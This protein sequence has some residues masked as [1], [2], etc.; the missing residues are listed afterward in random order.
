[1]K[2]LYA[3]LFLLIFFVLSV[4]A[5]QRL[6][7][8]H[9]QLTTKLFKVKSK[10]KY[11]LDTTQ[12]STIQNSSSAPTIIGSTIYDYQSNASMPR[13]IH[14]YANGRVTCI[15]NGS[16]QDQFYNDRG[17][18]INT[19]N[20]TSWSTSPLKR[21]ENKITGWCA[22]AVSTN[23]EH[24]IAEPNIISSNTGFGTAFDTGKTFTHLTQLRGP[25]A[26]ASG[27]YIHIVMAGTE[28]D[29]STGFVAPIYYTRSTNAGQSFEPMTA[30]FAAMAGYDTS[31]HAGNVGPNAYSIDAQGNTVAILVLGV[32]EDVVLLKSI[33]NGTTWT[34]TIIREFP[35]KKYTGGLTDKN[36]DGLMDT[37]LGVTGDGSIVIDNDGVVHVVFSDLELFSAD[38]GEI[39]IFPIN[40]SDYMNYWNDADKEIIEVPV[41]MDN[42]GNGIFDAGSNFTGNGN[43]R[44][45]NSGY[46]LNPQLSVGKSQTA[47]ED[48]IFL[49]YVAVLENDTN[50]IG[51]DFR[52]IYI[53]FTPNRGQDWCYPQN[54]SQTQNVENVYP[55][56]NRSALNDRK[57][58][59]NWQQDF[60][61][62]N[63]VQVQHVSGPSDIIYELYDIYPFSPCWGGISSF[64]KK[65]DLIT[66]PNPANTKIFVDLIAEMETNASI[67]FINILGQ[68]IY[69]DVISIKA[70][71]NS[72]VINSSDFN[73]G[74]YIMIIESAEGRIAQKIIIE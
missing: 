47:W 59:L 35:I 62:G 3:T 64:N 56:A 52:S 11:S 18:F 5:Q 46:S 44:Y 19:F 70:S 51:V 21:I 69:N 40:R 20:G 15:W 58:H 9:E 53:N 66:Y 67:K 4:N 12:K 2:T 6:K 34:K 31:K 41:L 29:T 27:Q 54:F 1:M 63:A 45:G 73:S 57:V 10:P 43:I 61:P 68:T 17:T 65:I 13:R 42:N 48:N 24:V 72:Y 7:L 37:V 23:A 22:L 74:V 71:N 30:N 14:Q 60:E 28:A 8:P 50:D 33:N 25:H 26:A 55:T 49:T 16:L 32:T 38:T 36:G 39:T